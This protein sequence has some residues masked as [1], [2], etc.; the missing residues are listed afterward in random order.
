MG[1]ETLG[2]ITHEDPEIMRIEN[3]STGNTEYRVYSALRA[4]TVHQ[5]YHLYARRKLAQEGVQIPR[6]IAI[7]DIYENQA[8]DTVLASFVRSADEGIVVVEQKVV[9]Q[10]GEEKQFTAYTQQRAMRMLGES[11]DT[12]PGLAEERQISNMLIHRIDSG[13]PKE[14]EHTPLPARVHRRIYG[15]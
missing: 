14:Y 9:S 10:H 13:N 7:Q 8:L 1:L 11:E 5:A 12:T 3:L 6:R 2:R 15:F 4:Q